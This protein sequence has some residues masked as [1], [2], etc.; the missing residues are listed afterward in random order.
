MITFVSKE[1]KLGPG[2][3]KYIWGLKGPIFI[4]S[5]VFEENVDILRGIVIALASSSAASSAASCKNF[6]I[7]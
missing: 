2:D 3:K 7:F 1:N 4:S 6:D 5:A